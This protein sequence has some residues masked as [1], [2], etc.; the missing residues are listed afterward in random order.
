MI[1]VVR[2]FIGFS[3][4]DAELIQTEKMK[5]QTQLI[6]KHSTILRKNWSDTCHQTQNKTI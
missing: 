2:K 3:I 1:F 5:Q 6:P 4:N